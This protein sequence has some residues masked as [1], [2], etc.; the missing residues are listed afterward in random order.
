[1]AAATRTEPS[2]RRVLVVEDDSDTRR[3]LVTAITDA[4][5]VAV[6]ALDGRHALRTAIALEPSAIVLDLMLPEMAG[7]EFVRAY[8]AQTADRGAPIVVL[9]ARR[10][11]AEVA[12]R[13]GARDFLAKPV[14]VDD[15]VHRVAASIG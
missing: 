6:P 2:P 12:K 8:R 14:D 4:G 1:M 9:S 13:I 10:D 7:D 3:M 11:G 5:Y 15:L